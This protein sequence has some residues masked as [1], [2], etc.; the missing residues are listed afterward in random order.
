MTIYNF[1]DF[2]NLIKDT[3]LNIVDKLEKCIKDAAKICNCNRK[4]K[5]AKINECNQMYILYIKINAQNIKKLLKT[6]VNDNIIIFKHSYTK[7][8]LTLD[9]R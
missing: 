6:K 4:L 2:Y 9:L 8:I 5:E 1:N 7:D 3:K